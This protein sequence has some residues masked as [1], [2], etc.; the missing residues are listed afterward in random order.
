MSFDTATSFLT[1]TVTGYSMHS[2][3]VSEISIVL[4]SRRINQV[5]MNDD[6]VLTIEVHC[7]PIS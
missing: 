1:T 4:M 5:R 3:D 7:Y 6:T 2:C